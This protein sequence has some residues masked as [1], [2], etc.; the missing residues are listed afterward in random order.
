MMS[1]TYGA[2]EQLFFYRYQKILPT[3]HKFKMSHNNFLLVII[4]SYV[5]WIIIVGG[6]SYVAAPDQTIAINKFIQVMGIYK[7]IKNYNNIH[8]HTP[9][10]KGKRKILESVA[11]YKPK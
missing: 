7:I 11:N 9:Y 2:I 3:G 5:I 10:H 8:D 4:S 6:S 1:G